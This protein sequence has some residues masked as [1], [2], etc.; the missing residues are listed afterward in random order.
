MPQSD[1]AAPLGSKLSKPRT[2][3]DQD[4]GLPPSVKQPLATF[5]LYVNRCYIHEGVRHAFDRMQMN[6]ESVRSP[7]QVF[8]FSD[9]YAPTHQRHLGA[10][11][12]ND[13]AIRGMLEL[14]DANA[15]QHGIRH[16]GLDD[17][18][19]GILHV[20]PPELGITQ[21]GLLIVGADSHTST[22]RR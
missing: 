6:G 19:Q 1:M 8:A 12:S 13:P 2:L 16:F 14:A 22:R 3:F 18:N 21:P 17:P 5:L 10:A 20:V 4:L 9:H 11:A 15:R 7:G